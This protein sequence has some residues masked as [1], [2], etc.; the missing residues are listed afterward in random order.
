MP[1]TLPGEHSA[2][3]IRTTSP[4]SFPSFLLLFVP[5]RIGADGTKPWCPF[6]FRLYRSPNLGEYKYILYAKGRLYK[7]LLINTQPATPQTQNEFMQEILYMDTYYVVYKNFCFFRITYWGRNNT[8]VITFVLPQFDEPM[9][10]KLQ[11]QTSRHQD[12]QT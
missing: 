1:G 2:R 4:G 7:P 8:I 5:S 9:I 3:L 12:R 6:Y 11:V 10:I